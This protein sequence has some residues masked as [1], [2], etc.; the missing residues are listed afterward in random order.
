MGVRRWRFI[1]PPSRSR[2]W[3]ATVPT[4]V[5]YR[6][7][8]DQSFGM[9]AGDSKGQRF[10]LS[11]AAI[12]KALCFSNTNSIGFP[13]I[14]GTVALYADTAGSKPG[15]LITSGQFTYTTPQRAISAVDVIRVPVAPIT[16]SA[17][18]YW[19]ILFVTGGN[20]LALPAHDEIGIPAFSQVVDL[21]QS[22]PPPDPFPAVTTTP[23]FFD[24]FA[25]TKIATG[26]TT[27][28]G[29]A[30]LALT[31]TTTT[32]GVRKT[33]GSSAVALTDAIITSVKRRTFGNSV[34]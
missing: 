29:S 8:T 23:Y 15:A 11:T 6:S 22:P 2:R 13:N 31:D 34:A 1:S 5:S 27:W 24:I 21:S 32:G 25:E 26:P 28:T 4:T 17:G 19:I 3:A 16:L 12:L 10:Q 30:T 14:S 33:F 20:G 18:F 9:F 7:I